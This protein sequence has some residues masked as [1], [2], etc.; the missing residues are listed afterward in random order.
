VEWLFG[1]ANEGRQTPPAVFKAISNF[2]YQCIL[3]RMPTNA[4]RIV[5]IATVNMTEGADGLP[6]TRAG[7]RRT[8]DA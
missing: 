3:S 2:Q 7:S 5:S 8:G 1:G 4:S 6:S